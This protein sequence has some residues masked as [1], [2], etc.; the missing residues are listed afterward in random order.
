MS[1][2]ECRYFDFF[3]LL[4]KNIIDFFSIINY[5]SEKS[6]VT[7]F[8]KLFN[9]FLIKKSASIIEFLSNPCLLYLFSLLI[10]NLHNISSQFFSF[11]LNYYLFSVFFFFLN[12]G[13]NNVYSV[14]YIT[15]IDY[16]VVFDNL[17][18]IH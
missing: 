18:F 15:R 8:K 7:L 16:F 12:T 11:D 10:I 4:C 13:V 9:L 1:N 3:L 17:N 6:F 2:H 14:N 5:V